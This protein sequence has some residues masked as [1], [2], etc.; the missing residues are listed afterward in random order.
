MS[1]DK[2]KVAVREAQQSSA[3]ARYWRER[4]Q[5]QAD[6]ALKVAVYSGANAMQVMAFTLGQI[7]AQ[8]ERPAGGILAGG[9]TGRFQ[10]P[11]VAGGAG[12]TDATAGPAE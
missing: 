5:K 2:L 7:A 6:L 12:N 11:P 3:E 4:C 8:S 9:A 1:E 10:L